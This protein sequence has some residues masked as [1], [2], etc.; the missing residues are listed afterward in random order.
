MFLQIWLCRTGDKDYLSPWCAAFCD[1]K[2]QSTDCVLQRSLPLGASESR[3]WWLQEAAKEEAQDREPVD[4]RTLHVVR[5][6]AAG[7]T[8]QHTAVSSLRARLTAVDGCLLVVDGTQPLPLSVR[9]CLPLLVQLAVVPVCFVT[10]LDAMPVATA[11]Q[12]EHTYQS[13]RRIVDRLN[14]DLASSHSGSGMAAPL[15]SAPIF[16]VPGNLF[17][18][19][20]ESGSVTFGSGQFGWGVALPYEAER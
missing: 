14:N 12:R 3:L 18:L 4:P 8:L 1:S 17:Q 9:A 16:H 7:M 5:M 11:A 10:K 13:L 19:S 20:P 15:V 2:E 6:R